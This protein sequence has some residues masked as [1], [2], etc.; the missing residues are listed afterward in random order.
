MPPEEVNDH[1]RRNQEPKATAKAGQ[2]LAAPI[3]PIKA[4]V[5][6]IL[7]RIILRTSFILGP[8]DRINLYNYSDIGI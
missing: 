4:K 6:T 1:I 8:V 5:L 2:G 3:A 7:A